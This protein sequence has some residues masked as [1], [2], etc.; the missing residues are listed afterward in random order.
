MLMFVMAS[1]MVAASDTAP[2]QAASLDG[3]PTRYCREMGSAAS[4]NQAIR[5]CRTR[6]QWLR[7]KACNDTTTYCAPAKR[8][9]SAEIGR[10]SAFPLNEDSRIIC[11]RLSVTG[12]RLSSQNTCL[13]QREW[14][15]MWDE[16]RSTM[17]TLQ[18][19]HSTNPDE[20]G[21]R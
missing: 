14:R 13:P 7:M 6:A 18:D 2:Q 19:R 3:V 1:V 21:P 9:A 11:R 10:E 17:S 16:S 5:V 4:R 20:F 12:T 8:M 15:R